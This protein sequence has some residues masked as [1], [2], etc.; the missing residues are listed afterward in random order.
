MSFII[1]AGTQLRL[2]FLAAMAS[3]MFIA[4]A[5]TIVQ[6]QLSVSV[7]LHPVFL[8]AG[9]GAAPSL[10]KPRMHLPHPQERPQELLL[11]EFGA[12]R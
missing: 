1:N 11:E 7:R 3:L 4:S 6:A 8:G 2:T 9:G 10:Q 12:T 5:T